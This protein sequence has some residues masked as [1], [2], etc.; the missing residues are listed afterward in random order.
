MYLMDAGIILMFITL[1]KYLEARAKGRA[2]VRDSQAARP[3][4][5]DWRYVVR[6][7][8]IVSVPAA[9]IAVGET[10]V[11]RP[12]EKIPLDAQVRAAALP[13]WTNPG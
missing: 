9:E 1:G 2:S 3:G 13:P 12:G 5:A 11:V 7:G 4:A 10:I 8:T 6:G